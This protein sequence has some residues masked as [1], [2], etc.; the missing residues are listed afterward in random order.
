MKKELGAKAAI[1]PCPVLIIAT[2]DEDGNAD[3]MNV[4]WGGQCGPAH[5]AINIAAAHKTTDNIKAK[6]AF[7]CSIADRQHMVVADYFGVESGK[8][9]DK[10]A[11]SGLTFRKSANVD[12]P[13]IEEFPLTMECKVIDIRVENGE[14]RVVGEIVNTIVDDSILTDDKIDLDKLQP[15]S[16]DSASAGYRIVGERIGNAFKDGAVMK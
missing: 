13:V 1:F 8:N 9:A 5:I 14:T 6:K 2:Y 16:F 7:T 11:K 3:A 10:A 12:A 15:L 4:A